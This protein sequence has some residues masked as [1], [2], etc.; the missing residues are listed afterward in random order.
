[1][2]EKLSGVG[3][4]ESTATAKHLSNNSA[5]PTPDTTQ[6][7]FRAFEHLPSA[8][9]LLDRRHQVEAANEIAR[10]LLK[11]FAAFPCQ[12]LSLTPA[13]APVPTLSWLTTVAAQLTQ[14][15]EQ[16]E[17]YQHL[18]HSSLCMEVQ[19]HRLR[20]D[21]GQVIGTL[22]LCTD[23]TQHRAIST[24]L[25]HCEQ[26]YQQLLTNIPGILS[27]QQQVE[28]AL[29]TSEARLLQ[30]FEEAPFGM[31]M[32]EPKDNRFTQA[33]QAFCQMVGYTLEELRFLTPLDITH[34]DDIE[35]EVALVSEVIQGRRSTLSFE[36]RYITKQGAVL[37]VNLRSTVLRDAE[38]NI[39]E[40][41][42]I[43]ENVTERKATEEALQISEE[44]FR[45]VVTNL[46]GAV[47]R[48]LMDQDWT[49]Q[50]ISQGIEALTG[51]PAQDFVGNERRS[52]AS[53]LHPDDRDAVEVT[54]ARAI[55]RRQ[56]FYA[57]YRCLTADGEIRWI[58]DQGQ[59]Y[60]DAEG[61]LLCLDGVLLDI[62]D[63]KRAE[64]HL[65]I[66]S[67]ACEQSPASIMITDA[68]GNIEYVNSRFE[69]V[70]GYTL[71]EVKGQN[72]RLLQSGHTSPDL[73]RQL[74]A[75]IR[76]GQAWYGEFHNRTK[77]GELFWEK[78]AISPIKD[79]QGNITHYIGVKEDITLHKETVEM[80]AYQTNFD[81]L[82][83]LPNRALAFDRLRQAL[84]Q[85]EK[86]QEYV[87]LLLVDLDNFKT[88]NET[89]GHD[90]GDILLAQAAQRLQHCL[91]KSDTAAR[92][93][94]DEFLLL[95]PGLNTLA[96]VTDL[97]HEVLV[98]L[99]RPYYLGSEEC[100]L[101][102]SMGIVTYPTDGDSPGVLLRN[103]EIALYNA[104][105]TGRNAFKF[106]ELGMNQAA[107]RRH[108]I[109][110][111]LRR[112]LD[113]QE[114][115]LVY[116]PF[117]DLT[118][119]HTV[120]AEALLR[121]TNPDIGEISPVEFIPVAEETGL[122]SS[123]GEWVIQQACQEAGNWPTVQNQPLWVAAHW[124]EAS[125]RFRE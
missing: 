72:P 36:K 120:G 78:A 26:Q 102:A 2:V 95:L 108:L 87:A 56:P 6:K 51:Y 48:C 77:A 9:I 35:R 39:R 105:N 125:K 15:C 46:P 92:L 52:F 45:T 23:I 104:K 94:G 27:A 97:A 75:T 123:I 118:Q 93:G 122:I 28:A 18:P 91:C 30:F 86:D 16:H 47:Y 12:P 63:R 68:Q 13:S 85:A 74:W 8:V 116:Q 80:L 64:E 98:Q 61:H 3:F 25:H 29:T 119:G 53:M 73:Y 42:G 124:E 57:E 43:V 62:S 121:W 38:G 112:A 79:C 66:L 44:R 110:S 22:L 106:F 7:Y 4:R 55:A 117:V 103:A 107:Q 34:P 14:D 88:I 31:A 11:Q 76:A 90:V 81:L 89:L 113:N 60:W 114:F 65:H 32:C 71:D 109:T 40:A 1:M 41:L 10:P 20:D 115:R 58:S 69:K 54:I 70:T 37:W 111:Y 17:I 67:E 50:F 33:N 83:A 100:F 84:N 5:E 96:G 24:A 21:A 19:F 101:S 59:G 82:T 49:V 99:E